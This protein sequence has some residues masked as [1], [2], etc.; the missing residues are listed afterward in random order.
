M[1][2]AQQLIPLFLILLIF[3]MAILLH[4]QSI[5]HMLHRE[6]WPPKGFCLTFY[7]LHCEKGCI[8]NGFY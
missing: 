5:L 1:I 6:M 3:L 4:R 7:P 8:T 2:L